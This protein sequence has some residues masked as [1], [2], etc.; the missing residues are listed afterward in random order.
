[1]HIFIDESGN[2]A[3]PKTG[4]SVSVMG[5]L[6]VPEA[7]SDLLFR[8]Y[9]RL[10][11]NLPKEKGEVKGRLLA[12]S[13]MA[14]VLELLRKNSCIFEAVAIDMGLET[15]EGIQRHREGQAEAL[16]MHL[17]DEHHPN[18]VAGV[19]GLRA[20]VESMSVPLYTQSTV[21]I[22]LLGNILQRVPNYW[23][24]RISREILNFHWV[25]DGK[26]LNRVTD[27]EDWWSTTMLG[28]LQSRSARDPMVWP[29][30]VEKGEFGAK[31]MRPMPDY[32]RGV[33]T[34]KEMVVDLTLLMKES[35]RFSSAP[36]PGLELADIVTNCARRALMGNL[37]RI[38][39]A[40]LPK[41]M[42]HRSQQYVDLVH[43]TNFES[44]ARQPYDQT[45]TSFRSGGRS[46]FTPSA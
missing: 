36:E 2:F 30:W 46:M 34:D 42:I 40:G 37:Q 43:L 19:W 41:L 14:K 45:L 28:L 15:D 31:F 10:R 39:W 35:F 8:K 17:T 9:E 26:E 12:E 3:R 22:F 7:R 6:V 23:V 24:Q 1:M 25:V 16:T 4:H 20:R 33:L 44:R 11:G 5:A 38:G 13:Q 32:L 27:A 29:D 18:L 21:T